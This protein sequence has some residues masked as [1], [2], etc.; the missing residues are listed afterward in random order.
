MI[1]EKELITVRPSKSNLV[2]LLEDI[3]KGRIKIPLFQRDFIWEQK[4][5]LELFD[6]IE[7]G[8]PIGS[9][10]FWK[11]EEEYEC[12]EEFGPYKITSESKDL[13]Y[14]LDGYQRLSTLF[15]VLTNPKKYKK[16]QNDKSL[17]QY[18]IYYDLENEEFTYNIKKS[19]LASYIPLY[20]LVDT[21]YFL[22]FSDELRTKIPNKDKSS[23]LI[24]RA[25]KL[26][27]K[28]IEYEIPFINITGGD[29]K[30]SVDIFS[31]VNS[32]GT[33]MSTDWMLSAL[34][35][36]PNEFLLT[37]RI[38]DFLIELEDYNFDNLSRNTIINCVSTATNKLHVDVKI[39][40]LALRPD[41]STL[42][43]TTLENIKKAIEFLRRE[44]N[45]VEYKLL[46]YNTQLIFLTEFFRL[47]PDPQLSNTKREELI[48]WFW[49]TSYSSYFTIYSSISR[50]RKALTLFKNFAKG[51]R[52]DSIYSQDK[53]QQFITNPFPNKKNF[54]STRFKSLILF[55]LN[56]KYKFKNIPLS[57][58]QK[59]EISYLFPK[60]RS[61]ANIIASKKTEHDFSLNSLP[62]EDLFTDATIT[63]LLS[64]S[65]LEEALTER[66][67]LMQKKE[68][69][70]VENL[71]LIYSSDEE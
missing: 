56:E 47:N 24:N 52:T 36:V 68:Q 45:V 7:K 40:D 4:Q 51:K 18:A 63:E 37:D 25:K 32:K 71:G 64:K 58:N 15:G 38:S 44:L 26:A 49:V 3:H 41:F 42:V 27:K 13:K 60:N 61:V 34:S 21:F 66:K 12:F 54:G 6:S 29:I 16:A 10:L 1:Q 43:E 55:I 59:L 20:I 9:L 31:R 14:V 53:N 28:I 70:F 23:L 65:L 2:N 50:Q 19:K 35:Y 39:E 8:Y 57:T 11:P 67:M 5:M 33:K 69:Q 46:P 48:K 62:K 17:R 22:D 30:S